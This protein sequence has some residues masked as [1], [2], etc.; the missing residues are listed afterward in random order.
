MGCCPMILERSDSL[1]GAIWPLCLDHPFI[2]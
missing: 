2:A 1:K